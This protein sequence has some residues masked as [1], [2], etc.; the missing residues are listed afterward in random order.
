MVRLQH[1]LWV[2]GF[3]V[4]AGVLL[5]LFGSQF[6]GYIG[7]GDGRQVMGWLSASFGL[8]TPWILFELRRRRATGEKLS[9]WLRPQKDSSKTWGWAALVAGVWLD[10]DL[11]LGW[12]YRLLSDWDFIHKNKT[13]R[14]FIDDDAVGGVMALF[15]LVALGMAIWHYRSG[16]LVVLLIA[17]SFLLAVSFGLTL[18]FTPWP[19]A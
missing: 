19:R 14:Q 7:G 16:K 6:G 1:V 12:C 17:I 4:V 18:L 13:Y 15:G 3:S 11:V 2:A 8:A 5:G 10:A 9:R